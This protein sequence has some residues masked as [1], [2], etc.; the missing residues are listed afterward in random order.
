[1]TW[2]DGSTSTSTTAVTT[3]A[4]AMATRATEPT[5]P[6]DGEVEKATDT[7]TSDPAPRS[8]DRKRPRPRRGRAEEDQPPCITTP[9]G[10]IENHVSLCE[11][12]HEGATQAIPDDI[13]TLIRQCWR[14]AES[15]WPTA[16]GGRNEPDVKGVREAL[17]GPL[18]RALEEHTKQYG[19]THSDK[20]WL[21]IAWAQQ[22]GLVQST[23]ERPDKA[24]E[25]IPFWVSFT[26]RRVTA[27][28]SPPPN[29][30]QQ[31]RDVNNGG[32]YIG[33]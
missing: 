13:S 24:G 4:A 9:L 25:P 15:A 14:L 11:D 33:R 20:T 23:L 2:M 5:G 27:R 32:S 3:R 29:E 10:R 30:G 1:M 16:T 28:S 18:R 6:G 12:G 26:I 31:S 22:N 7:R 19:G 17:R 8:D 21:L